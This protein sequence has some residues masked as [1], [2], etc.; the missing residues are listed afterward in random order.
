MDFVLFLVLVA[1]IVGN[2]FYNKKRND[3][4]HAKQDT[5][6]NAINALEAQL[7]ALKK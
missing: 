7:K 6:T 4:F 1:G 2:F 5:L 3:V